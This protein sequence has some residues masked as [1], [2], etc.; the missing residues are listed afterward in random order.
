MTRIPDEKQSL[1]PILVM[2]GFTVV[3]VVALMVRVYRA[4]RDLGMMRIA[5]RQ[6]R[7]AAESGIN[8][9][10]EKMRAAIVASDRAANPGALT[11]VF[12]ADRL[13]TD[14]WV[15]FG[16][17]AEAWFRII[18][19]RKVF[20]EDNPATPLLDESLQYQILS[21]GRCGRYRYSTSAV[22]QLYDLVKNF[23]VF[24]S[25]DEYYYGTPIQSWVEAAGSLD[26]F[27][28][29][30]AAV[31]NAGWL[32]RQ[33]VCHDPVLLFKMFAPEGGDPFNAA[34]GTMPLPYNYGRRFARAGESPCRGP[35]YCETPV[36]VDSH[37]FAGPVQTAM[38]FY[39]RG[40]SQPRIEQ[41]NN[42]VAMNSSL[43]M[44]HAVDSLE[45]KNPS[46]VFV[47]RDSQGYNSFIPPWRP[48]FEHLRS[49]SRS[50]GIYIDA[51]GKGFLNGKPHEIDYHPG[52]AHLFS[53]SYRGPNSTRYEQDELDEKYIVLSTDMRFKGFNNISAPNLQGARLIFSE[54]SVYLRGDI[55]SDL[56]IV[57]PGHIFIT[58]PT[59]IDSNL[60]L[61]LIAGEGTALSTVDLENYIKEANPGP[62]FISAASEWLI[63]AAIY[64]PGAG[65]Y[66][67]ESRPQQGTPITFRR[68]FGGE[69]LKI[70]IHGACIGG[71]LQRWV[72]NTEP[73]SLQI[74]HVPAIADR[75][76]LRPVSLN[77]L[78]MRTRP[79]K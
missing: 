43:R 23:G 54:R 62:E 72:D 47:D 41:G 15:Q 19:V 17:K 49:L 79:E 20:A 7:L 6:A 21:E 75:L 40:N 5:S 68:L 28:G 11:A 35:L 55:G 46:D 38:Y 27:V 58:G 36:V 18:S 71:N 77:V 31:F 10:I 67:A 26:S 73:G 34:T 48:D 39:R 65:V 60:N 13:E 70:R 66:S 53:D 42:A 1:L 59:N 2:V 8:H 52:E 30:N 45:G 78:R 33:G 76:S 51:D 24:G 57:T 14:A 56:V 37:T 22:V 29:A 50:R 32:N 74:T 69:S 4:D 3:L 12:F 63:R 61:L 25:L 44:Q 9:A 16:Q 64:K